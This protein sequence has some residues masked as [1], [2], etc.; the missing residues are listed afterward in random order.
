V[1]GPDFPTGGIIFDEK[2]IREAYVHGKGAIV[3][4]AKTDIT[5]RKK[6]NLILS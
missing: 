5:E 6:D 3:L 2:A 4:R 1:K